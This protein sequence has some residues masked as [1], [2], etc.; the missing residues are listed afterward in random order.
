MDK[1]DIISSLHSHEAVPKGNANT[2]THVASPSA[3]YS[4]KFLDI[5]QVKYVSYCVYQ[6]VYLCIYTSSC[7]AAKK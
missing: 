7:P 5:V 6:I 1:D 2:Q 3:D 4:G